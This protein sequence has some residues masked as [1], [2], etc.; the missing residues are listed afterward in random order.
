HPK[1]VLGA[2]QPILDGTGYVADVHVETV[3]DGMGLI[4]GDLGMS[5]FEE[6]LSDA[7]PRCSD[8]DPAAFRHTSAF[9]TIIESAASQLSA[10][11]VLMDVG[12][13][14][15]AINRAAL[16]A[17][18]YVVV[19]LA[20]DLFSLQ[21]LKNLGPTLRK[22]RIEWN[23]RK[24]KAQGK[25][26]ES[27]SLPSGGM[28]PVG[29]VLSQF[30]IRLDRPTKAYDRWARQ[31]PTVYSSAILGE[32][33]PP[34]GILPDQD[35][36]RLALLKH[37]RSLMPLAMEARKPIFDLLPA[38]GAIGGHM[39]AVRSCRSDFKDL[40]IEIARRISLSLPHSPGRF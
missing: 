5:G 6:R 39:D 16:I 15:G 27:I 31:I 7:W 37:Y 10:D 20:P 12:P 24:S 25:P 1:S 22:W 28:Q 32:P 14:L 19:P 8:K 21:G 38:D 34:T 9:H 17:A 29:Y 36:N 18:N 23:E 40:A 30:A 11:I 33:D 2:I 26:F 3:G 35:P 13:N 4:V